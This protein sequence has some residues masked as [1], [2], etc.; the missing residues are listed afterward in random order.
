MLRT[1]LISLVSLLSFSVL[2]PSQAEACG[3]RHKRIAKKEAP[4]AEKE[5][6]QAESEGRAQNLKSAFDLIDEDLEGEDLEIEGEEGEEKGTED[7]DTVEKPK[8]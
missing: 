1:C 7:K 3:M 6:A 5:V 4:Q 8:V 2:A